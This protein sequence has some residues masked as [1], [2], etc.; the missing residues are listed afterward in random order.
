MH[1][2]EAC[3]TRK[4][5]ESDRQHTGGDQVEGHDGV[6]VEGGHELRTHIHAL[7]LSVFAP[8]PRR[9]ATRALPLPQQSTSRTAR[10]CKHGALNREIFSKE[11]QRRRRGT[12]K[13]VSLKSVF[14]GHRAL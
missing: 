2:R 13:S 14:Q 10:H 9:V 11:A 3:W 6:G 5:Q 12:A 7:A 1:A 4:R 8:A